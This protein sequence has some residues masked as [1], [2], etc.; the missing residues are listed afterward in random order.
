MNNGNAYELSRACS[1]FVARR[2]ECDGVGMSI[3]VMWE[4]LMCAAGHKD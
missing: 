3:P 2:V 4:I 1:L